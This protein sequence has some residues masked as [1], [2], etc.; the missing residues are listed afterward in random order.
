MMKKYELSCLVSPMFS[1]K[2]I[3]ETQISIVNKIEANEGRLITQKADVA[4]RPFGYEI[5]GYSDGYLI[6]FVFEL[7]PKNLA[8]IENKLKEKKE[9]LR[10]LLAFKKDVKIDKRPTPRFKPEQK[11]T[12]KVELKEI[13]KKIE[14][15]LSE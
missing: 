11:P 8:N 9:I 5:K 7:E 13:D 10:Y 2:D 14:E 4:K 12:Q 1:E 3:L 6:S 15:I